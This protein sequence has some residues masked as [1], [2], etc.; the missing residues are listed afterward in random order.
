MEIGTDEQ[1]IDDLDDFNEEEVSDGT[2]P[3]TELNEEI[4]NEGD[5]FIDSLLRSRGIQD[6][7]KINF[8][9]DNGEIVEQNWDNLS[10]E[11][12]LNILNTSEEDPSQELDESEITLINAI[13]ESRLTP[14]E[15][16]NN[17]QQQS[18]NNYI[19]NA[20]DAQRSYKID[21]YSD[22]E[23]FI[24]DLMSKASD[25]TDQEA[26]EALEAAKSN[27]ALFQKQ[28][29]AIRN[30]LKAQEDEAIQ[31]AQFEQ[32]E[33]ERERFNQYSSQIADYIGEFDEFS[34]YDLN[35]S[36]EDRD[37]L[38]E[39][40][41]GVD[42]AGNNH[43]AKALSDPETLV[44]A[45]WLTLNG[46]QMIED[47]TNYF[48]NEIKQVRKESYKKGMEDAKK[49]T[50]VAFTNKQLKDKDYTYDDLDNF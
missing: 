29:E 24:F 26:Q 43:F 21:E 7:T 5:D 35:L 42:G 39:F 16:L 46:Q 37:D 28:V 11:E 31:Q 33:Q 1:L 34:G 45:A 14:E 2:E 48:Q 22:D 25:I 32:E 8:T 30:Q 4:K 19:Q 44:K 40:I 23:L 3:I 13:R 15:Y 41:T 36:N 27:E 20:Q 50:Q 12:K 10:T 38:Y 49:G 6:R 47:I 17:L 9:D 18:V